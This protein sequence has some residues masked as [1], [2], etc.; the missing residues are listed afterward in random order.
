MTR[1]Y[2]YYPINIEVYKLFT[3][4]T[5]VCQKPSLVSSI[6]LCPISL[7]L[8]KRPIKEGRHPIFWASNI[9]SGWILDAAGIHDN[10]SF[11]VRIVLFLHFQKCD[12]FRKTIVTSFRIISY[13]LHNNTPLKKKCFNPGGFVFT[14][15]FVILHVIALAYISAPGEAHYGCI[16]NGHRTCDHIAYC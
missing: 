1:L 9:L 15:M 12:L 4:L 14:E 10:F 5:G 11:M 3:F 16:G 13:N 6:F 8:I 7:M 2:C